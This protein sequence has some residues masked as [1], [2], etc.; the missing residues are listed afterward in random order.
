MDVKRFNAKFDVM[1]FFIFLAGLY[2]VS[3]IDVSASQAIDISGTVTNQNNKPISG[4]I[5][6]LVQQKKVADTTTSNGAFNLKSQVGVKFSPRLPISEGISLSKGIVMINLTEPAPVRI[7]V[8]DMSGNLLEKEFKQS[9][10]AGEYRLDLTNSQFAAKMMVVRAAIGQRIMSFRYIP[11]TSGK[12][13]IA[14]SIALPASSPTSGR[15]AKIQATV[16][17]LYVSASGYYRKTVAVSAYSDKNIT[18][19]LD[20]LKLAR[21][22]FFV[23]SLAALQD[24][25][26]SDKGFGGDLRFGKTGQGAGLLGADSIC[27]CIAEKSMAGSKTKIWRAFLSVTKGANGKQVNAIDRIGPGPWYD[28]LGRLVAPNLLALQ[29]NR[30]T[31][32]DTLIKNDLP[33]ENGVPNHQPDPNEKAVDNHL[34][35]TGSDSLGKLF[36]ATA[37]CE[38]WTSVSTKNSKPRCGLSWTRLGGI[39]GGGGFGGGGFGKVSGM[40]GGGMGGGGMQMMTNMESWVSVWNLPGCYPGWDLS[41]STGPGKTGDT[42]I[43]SGGGY[44]GFYC[45]ALNP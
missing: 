22:S 12:R 38:D 5:V 21:F 41:E 34:T 31:N 20:T 6:A 14:S 15:L 16:D 19:T 30:P 27:Q 9:A 4:A 26:G 24:L 3:A 42:I 29:H 8:F 13:S 36:S 28:R 33:N 39:W 32:I 44:G 25:S 35:I 37:T 45:Y 18:V 10:S 23:T 2:F 43:G 17:S 7:E 1:G 40:G 11:L